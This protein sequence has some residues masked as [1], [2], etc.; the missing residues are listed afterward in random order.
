M[1]K[2]EGIRLRMF[3]SEILPQ[4]IVI[5]IIRSF[6]SHLFEVHGLHNVKTRVGQ[7]VY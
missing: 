2:E 5:V 3:L 7:R 4:L 1:I 6:F